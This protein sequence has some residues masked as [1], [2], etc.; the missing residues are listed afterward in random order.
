MSRLRFVTTVIAAL[1]F[2]ALIGLTFVQISAQARESWLFPVAVFLPVGFLL[3]LLMGPRRWWAAVAFSVLGAAWIE[4]AQS[5][6][7]PEGYANYGDIL[8]ATLGASI[9]VITGALLSLPSAQAIGSHDSPSIVTQA[10]SREI[11]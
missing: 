4:A 11:P 1:Y 6:W 3:V 10:G 7:M 8:L 5:I 9:G 2:G